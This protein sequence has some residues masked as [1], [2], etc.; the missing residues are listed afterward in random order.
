MFFYLFI[1]RE[2][3]TNS[4]SSFLKILEQKKAKLISKELLII[5]E[6][7]KIINKEEL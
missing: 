5:M 1:F 2:D 7:E 4:K 3:K 6:T